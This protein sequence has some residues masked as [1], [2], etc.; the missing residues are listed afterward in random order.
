MSDPRV[1]KQCLL[2]VRGVE[3]DVNRPSW[4]GIPMKYSDAG[5]LVS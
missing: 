2:R 4:L 3:L 5:G 1:S